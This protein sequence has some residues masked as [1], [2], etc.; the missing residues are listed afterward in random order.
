MEKDMFEDDNILDIKNDNAGSEQSGKENVSDDIYSDYPKEVVQ[1]LMSSN[2]IRKRNDEVGTFKAESERQERLGRTRV[3]KRDSGFNDSLP[4]E[5]ERIYEKAVS[6]P[7]NK[8][9]SEGAYKDEENEI[10]VPDIDDD[11]DDIAQTVRKEAKKPRERDIDEDLMYDEDEPVQVIR[12]KPKKKEYSRTFQ[13]INKEADYSATK[14][15]EALADKKR[16]ARQSTEQTEFDELKS[17][18]SDEKTDRKKQAV[19]NSRKQSHQRSGEL[20][21]RK[22]SYKNKADLHDF[23]ESPKK[24]SGR[25]AEKKAKLDKGIIAV[26]GVAVLIFVI[27]FVRNLTISAKL[28]AA[29]QKIADYTELQE[30][31]EELKLNIV[32]LEEKLTSHGISLTDDEPADTPDDGQTPENGENTQSGESGNSG[33]AEA[34]FD[35]Y[36]VQAGDTLGGISDK[37]YGN[38]SGYKKILEANG[39]TENSSLQIGQVLKIPKN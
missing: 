28:E 32:A 6:E 22:K 9:A 4:K 13:P 3:E 29:N 23:F 21:M 30:K 2:P 16:P 14:S 18:L 35:T 17:K 39:L 37:V 26:C 24:G 12:H 20:E 5:A 27:L 1:I 25:P 19:L 34:G 10:F 8:N 31:N 11:F 38:F 36:T 33:Q 15:R 7:E